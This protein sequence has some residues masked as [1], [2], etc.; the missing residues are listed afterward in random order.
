MNFIFCFLL[1]F[2]VW[3]ADANQELNHNQNEFLHSKRTHF[4]NALNIMHSGLNKTFIDLFPEFKKKLAKVYSSHKVHLR[5]CYDH[6][7]VKNENAHVFENTIHE[8]VQKY[9]VS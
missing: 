7:I 9:F 8:V 6:T 2:L 3:F 5:E 1:F 4:L